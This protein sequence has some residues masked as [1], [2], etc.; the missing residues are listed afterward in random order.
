MEKFT[1]I[2]NKVIK[3][4]DD[5]NWKNPPEDV[6]KSIMIEA[7]ELLEHF[8]W[9]ASSSASQ[10]EKLKRKDKAEIANEVADIFWY[11]FSFCNQMN[12]DPLEAIEKKYTHNNKK[13][14]VNNVL[15][16]RGGEFY[17]AQKR[18]YRNKKQTSL[19]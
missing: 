2:F 9:D 19:S 3:F 5:R 18:K 15:H 1:K 13:Y 14:P 12:I 7:A 11:L 10:E 16:D 8:Q 17:K 6:A 4:G